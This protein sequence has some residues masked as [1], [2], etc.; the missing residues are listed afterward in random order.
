MRF[1]AIIYLNTFSLL[2][3]ELQWHKYYISVIVPQAPDAWLIIFQSIAL[4]FSDWIIPIVLFFSSLILSS[5]SS[6][7]PLSR[8]L[9]FLFYY[10]FQ[11]WNLFGS[12]LCLLFLCWGFLFYLFLS[13]C[14]LYFMCFKCA[15][16]CILKH[17]FH[18]CFKTFVRQSLSSQLL[19][20]FSHSVW[21][22]P[23][24]SYDM[25]YSIENSNFHVMSW[26][27]GSY[28]NL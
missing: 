20:V 19:I 12:F 18:D 8:S 4:Y 21:Y 1:P 5:I 11:F 23:G 16:N 10:I 25:W 24:Y 13:W 15:P 17:Y 28:L 26:D 27:F 14:F 3:P 2:L 9:N 22:L 6:I 7:L